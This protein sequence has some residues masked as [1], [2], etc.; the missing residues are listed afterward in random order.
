MNLAIQVRLHRQQLSTS[1]YVDCCNAVIY[2]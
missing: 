2:E 1:V